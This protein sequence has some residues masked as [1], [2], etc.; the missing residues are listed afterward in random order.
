MYH[1]IISKSDIKST[2]CSYPG[3]LLSYFDISSAEVKS[4]GFMSQ[5][6][7]L[8]NMFKNGI[9]VYIATAKAYVKER[10]DTLSK[11]EQK[12][13]RKTFKTVTLALIYGQGV[14]SLASRLNITKETAQEIIDQVYTSYPKLRE[15]VKKQ[16]EYPL[17]HNGEVSTF[18]G[19]R[20]VVDEWK[21]YQ[22][23]TSSYE[24]KSLA[25]RIGREG[26]NYPIQGIDN[27]QVM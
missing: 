9:D 21:Y 11:K 20:L 8:I 3:H 17:Q 13:F 15:Y 16:Q 24:K 6:E 18:F 25:A 12:A 10:W 22:K 14:N 23:A 1:I 4:A 5:D 7:N 27:Q 19:D 26:C 2:I